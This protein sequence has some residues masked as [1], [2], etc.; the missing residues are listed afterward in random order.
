MAQSREG[1]TGEGVDEAAR[2]DVEDFHT[3]VAGIACYGE[4]GAECHIE[5]LE[6]HM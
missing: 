6:N 3:A 1:L 2:G 5:A 4:I